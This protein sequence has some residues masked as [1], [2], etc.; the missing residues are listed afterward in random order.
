MTQSNDRAVKASS[1]VADELEIS[2]DFTLKEGLGTCILP[3]SWLHRLQNSLKL[4]PSPA[5][6]DGIIWSRG[7]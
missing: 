3:L 4:G 7:Y 1:F 2:L 6:G 5:Q